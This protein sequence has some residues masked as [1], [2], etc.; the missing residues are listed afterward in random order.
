M[1]NLQTSKIGGGGTHYV[2]EEN[3]PLLHEEGRGKKPHKGTEK[4][5]SYTSWANHLV[6]TLATFFAFPLCIR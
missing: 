2:L 1:A 6:F 4:K 3:P 5:L